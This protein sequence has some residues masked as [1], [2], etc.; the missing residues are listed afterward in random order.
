[1]RRELEENGMPT[2]WATR[3]GPPPV[4]IFAEGF[5]DGMP[6][7]ASMKAPGQQP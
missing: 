3:G 7:S 4:E 5:A 6:P 2:T 1:M